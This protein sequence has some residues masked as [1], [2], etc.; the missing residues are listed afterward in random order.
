MNFFGAPKNITVTHSKTHILEP[1]NHPSQ[2][3]SHLNQTWIFRFDIG[4]PGCAIRLI[5]SQYYFPPPQL[6]IIKQLHYHRFGRSFWCRLT[7]IDSKE[8]I[9]STPLIPFHIQLR[10]HPKY[11]KILNLQPQQTFLCLY[12]PLKKKRK[13]LS[14]E[15]CC[16]ETPP[17]LICRI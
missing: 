2:E 14:R 6:L 15:K 1:K 9:P 3:E 13:H 17:G 16:F 11:P 10:K 8:K 12:N 7:L 4:F 5:H